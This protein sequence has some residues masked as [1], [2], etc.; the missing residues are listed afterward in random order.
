MSGTIG[1]SLLGAIAGVVTDRFGPTLPIFLGAI[2][3]LAGYF[4]LYFA[5]VNQIS[6]LVLLGFGSCLAGFGSTMAYSAAIKTAALNFPASR[7]TAVAFPLAAFGLSALLFSTLSA[8]Y[9]PGDTAG[10]L[11]L[12]GVGTSFL[13]LVN[14]PFVRFP[15]TAV[16]EKPALNPQ[17]IQSALASS[18]KYGTTDIR[19]TDR[20]IPSRKDSQSTLAAPFSPGILT[21]RGEA[22]ARPNSDSSTPMGYSP[23][24]LFGNGVKNDTDEITRS[25]S[26]SMPVIAERNLTGWELIG[27]SEFWSQFLILGLLAGVGQMYIYCVGYIVRAL[28][29]ADTTGNPPSVPAIQSLQVA[30]ISLFSFVSRL[31]SGSLSD[32]MST[33]LGLQ[34]LWM[35]CIAAIMAFIAHLSMISAVTS[36]SQLWIISCFVGVSYGLAF[37]V[38]PTIVCDTFGVTHLSKNW[39][40]VATSPVFSIYA[41][42][43]VF[44]K[45]YDKHSLG[46]HADSH[47]RD[48]SIHANATF[49]YEGTG[50]YS[51]TFKMTTLVSLFCTLLVLW[52][53]YTKKHQHVSQINKHRSSSNDVEQGRLLSDDGE[54]SELDL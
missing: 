34:R 8:I 44:G 42:N 41:F 7:G 40:L 9:F 52:M 25:M 50:C 33:R 2:C 14:L 13:C 32:I 27:T 21:P 37:G 51:E 4:T 16:S 17:D 43:L 38:F 19:V 30:L 20:E 29:L 1:V 26:P 12:L 10:F 15:T 31:L 54:E 53:I 48:S 36:A 28:V 11:Q 35:V 45:V 23:V 39:G 47:D 3:L 18:T 46:A 6:I 22:A 49:C 24:T 5:Y